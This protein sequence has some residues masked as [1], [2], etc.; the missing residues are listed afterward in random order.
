MFVDESAR[1]AVNQGS[2]QDRIALPF[3][4]HVKAFTSLRPQKSRPDHT[5]DPDSEYNCAQ[6]VDVRITL[7]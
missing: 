7:W 5:L 1:E 3:L 6:F 2:L 4:S